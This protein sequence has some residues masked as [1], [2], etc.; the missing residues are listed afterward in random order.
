MS[1][2]ALIAGAGIGGLTAALALARAGFEV[3]IFERTAVL[4]EFGA[5]LQLT[6]NATR[7]LAKLDALELVRARAMAPRA[8]RILRG[9][10]GAQLTALPLASAE[11]RWGAPYLVLHRADL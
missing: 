3:A 2:R 4:E 9:R 8:I 5:G 10:S 1:G 11:A 7:V 6:P